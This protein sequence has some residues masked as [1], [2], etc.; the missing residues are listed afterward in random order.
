MCGLTTKLPDHNKSFDHEYFYGLIDADVMGGYESTPGNGSGALDDMTSY[1]FSLCEFC[2]DHLFSNFVIPPKCFNGD[3]PEAF[4]P[5]AQQIKED[6]WRDDGKTFFKEQRKRAKARKNKYVYPATDPN[7]LE[8]KKLSS[9]I[10][11]NKYGPQTKKDQTKKTEMKTRMDELFEN[12]SDD[13]KSQNNWYVLGLD[14]ENIPKDDVLISE[15]D[16]IAYK[17]YAD[18][19]NSADYDPA[20]N[21]LQDELLLKSRKKEVT[22]ILKVKYE[23]LSDTVKA[24][25]DKVNRNCGISIK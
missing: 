24:W 22:K 5:A 7:I 1:H 2:L 4:I 13:F 3:I 25:V 14:E 15:E 21:I 20:G 9:D 23:N 11:Y 8:W 17:K 12:F 6:H 19:A 16:N 18:I 10:Q